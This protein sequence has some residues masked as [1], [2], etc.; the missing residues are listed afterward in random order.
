M[1]SSSAGLV[2]YNVNW[3]VQYW[4]VIQYSEILASYPIQCNAGQL[5]NTVQCWP[6]IQAAARHKSVWQDLEQVG[7]SLVIRFKKKICL[8]FR[9]KKICLVIR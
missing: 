4:L 7:I 5:S 6:V 9:F 1:H 2:Q 8:V 3:L